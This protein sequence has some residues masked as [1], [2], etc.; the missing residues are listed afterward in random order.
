[1]PPIRANRQESAIASTTIPT[2]KLRRQWRLADH[3]ERRR[4]IV[5][6]AVRLLKKQGLDSVT[7]RRVAD[8]LGVGAMTLYTYVD[9]QEGLR[10]AMTQHGFDL[11]SSGCRQASTLGTPQ[12]W[13]GS[14]EHY[15]RFAIENP[16]LY[17]LMFATEIDSGKAE[18]QILNRG[19]ERLIERV[20]EEMA[21]KGVPAAEIDRSA[22]AVAGRYWIALHGLA[23]LAIAGRLGVLKSDLRS[24]LTSL[25]ERVAPT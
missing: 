14:A 21:A 25:L 19:F 1:M 15:L 2:L 5:D 8:C 4:L 16:H 24:L 17:K 10:L 9:G 23:S 11:L 7:I 20:R 13:Q 12:G 3:E 6:V 22:L 18:E